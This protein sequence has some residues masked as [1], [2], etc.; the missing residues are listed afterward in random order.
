MADELDLEQG[1]PKFFQRVTAAGKER[2]AQ[3]RAAKTPP[4]RA[5][6]AAKQAADKAED[7]WLKTELLNSFTD[8]QEA[9]QDEY[10]ADLL[11][12]RKDQM[13]SG[14]VALTRNIRFLRGPVITMVKFVQPIMAFRELI[15]YKAGQL[16]ERLGNRNDNSDNSDGPVQ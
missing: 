12:R 14:L 11:G 10:L 1:D 6:T 9:T 2:T 15:A 4:S 13:A 3:A 5:S 7:G 8:W 16:F